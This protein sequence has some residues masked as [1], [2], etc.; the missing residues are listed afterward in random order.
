MTRIVVAIL[1]SLIAMLAFAAKDPPRELDWLELMP[2]DEVDALSEAPVVEHQGMFKMEQQGSFRTIPELNDVYVKL[3]GYIVPVDVDED[4]KMS[5]FFLVPYFGACIHVPPP[6]P[7]QIVYVTLEKPMDVTDIYD[8]FWIEGTLK[9]EA[10]QKEIAASAYVL[11]ADKV[12][13]YEG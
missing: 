1:F 7:N 8:A 3:P 4:Q 6:P 2:K 10:V 12:T 5:S 9:V 13:L 11:K